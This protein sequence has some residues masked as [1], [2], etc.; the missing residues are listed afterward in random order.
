MIGLP[1]KMAGLEVIR[2]RMSLSSTG[3]LTLLHI[4]SRAGDW[5][6]AVASRLRIPYTP[7][8]GR[9]FSSPVLSPSFS[10]GTPALSRTVSRR[11]VIG[12]SSG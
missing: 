2:R 10:A 5:P 12:V 6:R 1:P 9:V 4:P 8:S 11:L 7:A 3:R